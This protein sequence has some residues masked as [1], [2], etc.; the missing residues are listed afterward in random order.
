[1]AQLG[2]PNETVLLLVEHAETLH[3]F[4]HRSLLA[5]LLQRLEDR[6]ERRK[7]DPLLYKKK[8]NQLL[9]ESISRTTKKL[10]KYLNPRF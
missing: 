1:M 8:E 5:A 7:V 6:H 3:E 10:N 2:G 9:E 4:V